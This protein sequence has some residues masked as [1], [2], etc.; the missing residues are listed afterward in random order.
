M[1]LRPPRLKVPPPAPPGWGV[2]DLVRMEMEARRALGEADRLDATGG[3]FST[4]S[5]LAARRRAV[6]FRA[7]ASL[8]PGGRADLFADRLTAWLAAENIDGPALDALAA[9]LVP[10][11]TDNPKQ[12]G[13]G[14]DARQ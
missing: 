10:A 6:R 12:N 1:A 4:Q 5:S 3:E 13:G 2:R 11:A 14:R 9:C 7:L 8:P